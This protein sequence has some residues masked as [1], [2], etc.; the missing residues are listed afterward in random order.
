MEHAD[1]FPSQCYANRELSWLQF[2]ERVLEEAADCANPLMERLNFVSIFQS[3]L[4]EFYMVRVGMLMD[5]LDMGITD[6]KLGMTSAQQLSAVLERTRELLAQRDRL[7]KSLM[8][9]LTMSGV[10]L[11]RFSALSDKTQA[12]LEKYFRSNVLPLLSPQIVGRKQPFP[13][14]RNKS[15]YAIASLKS[16]DGTVSMGI[17]PCE[18]GVLPRLVSV[19]GEGRR[20][21]LMEELILGF[22]PKVFARCKVEESVLVRLVRSADIEVDDSAA[23]ADDLLPEEYRKR[24]E[25]LIRRRK[26][27]SPVK[28]EY[29]G[30]MSDPLRSSLSKLLGLSKKHMFAGS[31]PLDLSLI[32]LLRDQL[33]E[34]TTL[35]YPR[36]VPQDSPAVSRRQSVT[37]QIRRR[38]ILLAY[39]Y[40]SIRPLLRLLREAGRDPEVVSIRISL[41][42]VARNSK[43][44]EALVDAAENGKDVTAVVEL[45]ARFDEENN[46]GWSRV[47]ED[48]GCRVIYGLEGMKVHAKLLL[49]T[50]MHNGQVEYITHV[51]TGNY[52]EDTVRLYTD[53]SLLTARPEIG[54]EV[55]EV[56]TGLSMGQLVEHTEQLLVSPLGLR[57][58]V[59]NRI[60]GEILH[61]RSGAEA[62]LGF[63]LNGL[64]DK[65]II[66]KL[67]EASRA[68]VHIDL[69]VRGICCLVGGVPGY[70]DNIRVCSIVGRYLEHSRIYIFGTQD[71]RKVY[72]SS[73]DLMTRNTTR[74]VEVA[75]PILDETLSRRVEGMFFDQLRDTAKLRLQQPDG[76]Y[77]S[78][79]QDSSGLYNSQEAFAGRASASALREEDPENA[80]SGGVIGWLKKLFS[81][82]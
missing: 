74:R 58:M 41:Y 67:I 19:P 51:G 72:I 64:T 14:L 6:D 17:V 66:D 80:P 42:R 38:D 65:V 60:D 77:R 1:T 10:E 35:F 47:L 11:C 68:G 73:A 59:L 9:E 4:D 48:A 22:L 13:F 71:R 8:Q 43:I 56:L 55:A 50:R 53:L 57:P 5:T 34:D 76:T 30:R 37:E 12:V 21:V 3:N 27:L 78:I 7:F 2:N 16:K 63:K 40:E 69:L 20:F 18:D 61:A 39:P 54:A 62:Y 70:T 75:A 33:R 49:I 29:K 32:S 82:G 45:K 46:I 26:K 25:K 23:D 79:R 31:V 36:R 52:N 44:I 15:I 28:L 24:M 81:K